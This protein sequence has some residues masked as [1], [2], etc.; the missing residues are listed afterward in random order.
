[1]DQL[2]VIYRICPYNSAKSPIYSEDKLAL[3]LHN[4]DSFQKAFEGVD[5]TMSF[6]TDSC[7]NLFQES[8]SYLIRA[9]KHFYHDDKMGNDKSLAKAIEIACELPDDQ[10]VYFA[11]DDYVYIPGAGKKLVEA[12]DVFDFVTLYDHPDYYTPP[13][14]DI[15]KLVI[16]GFNHHWVS[17]VATCE[18]YGTTA[19]LVKLNKVKMTNYGAKDYQM[20]RDL[21]KEY[22]LFSPVPSLATHL[23]SWFLAPNIDWV[24]Y[25]NF[26]KECQNLK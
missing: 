22:N 8:I 4:L 13:Q 19:K 1:M 2:H 24:N 9:D 11:E 25:Y 5:Y 26:D 23:V 6:I 10:K 21:T 14:C 20:W 7:P 16:S 18:T 12:L 15:K 17:Q 3:V